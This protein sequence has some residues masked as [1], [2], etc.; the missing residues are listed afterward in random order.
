MR[1]VKTGSGDSILSM[2]KNCLMYKAKRF[3]HRKTK[4]MNAWSLA[5]SK[6]AIS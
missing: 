5:K 6:A 4:H 2:P 3:L 1:D